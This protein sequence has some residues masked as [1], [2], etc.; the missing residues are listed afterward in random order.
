MGDIVDIEYKNNSTNVVVYKIYCKDVTVSDV[1]IGHTTNFYSRKKCHEKSCTTS[2]AKVYVFIRDHGGWDNWC[3][4]MLEKYTC[5][6]RGQSSRLEWLWWTR[7]GGALNSHT[8]GINYI[9]RDIKKYLTDFE[10]YIHELEIKCKQP[11]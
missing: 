3:M 8:P 9:R 4:D 6:N 10:K 7:L 1:Y 5:K 11:S 2:S